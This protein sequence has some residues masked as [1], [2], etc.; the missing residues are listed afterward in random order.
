MG[1]SQIGRHQRSE[2]ATPAGKLARGHVGIPKSGGTCG[3]ALDLE[4]K[5]GEWSV[6]MRRE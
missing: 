2:F 6:L 1:E 4:S 5:G 3:D